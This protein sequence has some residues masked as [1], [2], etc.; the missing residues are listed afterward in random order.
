[1][2]PNCDSRTFL[3][4]LIR[5]VSLEPSYFLYFTIFNLCEFIHTNLY[6]QKA[7][8]LDATCEPDLNTPCDDK[9]KGV[10]FVTHINSN[11][12]FVKMICVIAMAILATT[13]SDK[14]GKK[15][16]RFII[17]PVVGLLVQTAGGCLFSYFWTLPA[18]L[19]AINDFVS[20]I[21]CGSYLMFIIF[22]QIYISDLASTDNRTMRLGILTAL[23][24]MSFVIGRGV[25][26]YML[27]YLGFFWSYFMCLVLSILAFALAVFLIRDVSIPVPRKVRW[28]EALD[29]RQTKSSIKIIFG[30]GSAIQRCIV[31]LLF[32]T[33][34]LLIFINE[35]N[36]RIY[37]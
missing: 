35:G 30:Q 29:I 12:S 7:C 1:M 4:R 34:A 6:I 14:A 19:T 10:K 11:F 27:R 28:Y 21:F 8:R 24:L 9:E 3:R 31:C 25:A 17:L 5:N 32:V 18:T 23:K 26:G 16:K 22:S 33:H 15:R 2:L 37:T 20:Q 13:W 36:I